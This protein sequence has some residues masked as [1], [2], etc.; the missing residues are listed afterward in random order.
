MHRTVKPLTSL[1][2][3]C[4][5]LLLL[6][7]AYLRIKGLTTQSYWNDELASIVLTDPDNSFSQVIIETLKDRSPLLYQ[8]ILWDWFK[9]FGF[10]EIAGRSLSAFTGILAI[11]AMYFM[12][13]ECMNKNTALYAVLITGLNNFHIYYSQ[14]VR[15]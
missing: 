15:S 11:P 2:L 8:L 9:L 12:A 14:E 4:L 13:R 6:V 10:T 3:S 5:G 1:H 7:S